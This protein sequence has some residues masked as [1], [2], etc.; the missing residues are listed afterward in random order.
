MIRFTARRLWLFGLTAVIA[1]SLAVVAC[2]PMEQQPTTPP[3]LATS[4]PGLSAGEVQPLD[5]R[6][7]L[8]FNGRT[9][10]A[11]AEYQAE[12]QPDPSRPNE[13]SAGEEGQIELYLVGYAADI[14]HPGEDGQGSMDPEYGEVAIYRNVEQTGRQV[15]TF[16]LSEGASATPEPL[17]PGTPIGDPA[18]GEAVGHWVRWIA[19]S[20]LAANSGG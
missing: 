16:T 7:E 17:G 18:E 5:P 19:E 9:F 3:E 1:A 6:R 13:V 12:T 4:T 20:T 10:V 11:T 15:F 14:Q 8:I 2:Q